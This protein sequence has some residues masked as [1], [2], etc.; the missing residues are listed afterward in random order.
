MTEN[1]FTWEDGERKRKFKLYRPCP[2][3]CD[4]RGGLKGVGYL[5]GSDKKGNGFTL[6]VE[7]EEVYQSIEKV[8]AEQ[9]K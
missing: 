4:S 2:C 5:T 7:S 3:G 8:M 1:Q 6:W 9:I